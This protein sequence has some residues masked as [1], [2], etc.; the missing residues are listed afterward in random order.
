VHSPRCGRPPP[1]EE[2]VDAILSRILTWWRK[3]HVPLLELID[4][5]VLVLIHQLVEGEITDLAM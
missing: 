3:V 2:I 5:R 4:F 1:R